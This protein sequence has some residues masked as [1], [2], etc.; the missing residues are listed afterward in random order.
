LLLP[1]SPSRHRLSSEFVVCS[2]FPK[3]IESKVRLSADSFLAGRQRSPVVASW[4]PVVGRRSVASQS[5]A[6]VRSPGL[7]RGHGPATSYLWSQSGCGQSMVGVAMWRRY[8]IYS[9]Y[10]RYMYSRY[11]RDTAE[12][13]QRYSRYSQ[14]PPPRPAR[15]SSPDLPVPPPT[16]SHTG[17][18]YTP[19]C[20]LTTGNSL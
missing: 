1:P 16:T 19:V 10:S 12:I 17:K 3:V 11:S 5:P 20:L 13:Q 18:R 7:K 2:R 6:V 4:S 15:P 8:S 14:P 9:R